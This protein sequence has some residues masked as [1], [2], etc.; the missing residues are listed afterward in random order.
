MGINFLH[1]N[2]FVMSARPT[3]HG[4]RLLIHIALA[5]TA[6]ELYSIA[7][8]ASKV[9]RV[10]L[11][12]SL[13]L[14]ITIKIANRIGDTIYACKT[15]QLEFGAGVLLCDGCTGEE[16]PEHLSNHTFFRVRIWHAPDLGDDA[17]TQAQTQLRNIWYCEECNFVGGPDFPYSHQHLDFSMRVGDLF[18]D[19][20]FPK[21]SASCL[22]N[23][24]KLYQIPEP[25]QPSKVKCMVCNKSIGLYVWNVFC[26][27]C[28]Q[29][30]CKVCIETQRAVHRHTLHWIRLDQ[31]TAQALQVT[32]LSKFLS[33]SCDSCG[34]NFLS[35]S[36]TGL[37]CTVCRNFHFCL[38]N[39]MQK[40]HRLPLEHVYCKG[41]LSSWELKFV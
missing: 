24:L 7:A 25:P 2:L 15:C 6:R 9:I 10:F 32:T 19:A 38:A 23:K 14:L 39:C 37:L 21:I 12:N 34:T 22:K 40:Q 18:I 26:M 30:I 11:C 4:N 27:K 41:R 28:D 17:Q 13:S 35:A 33:C 31:I 1:T 8:G 3:G 29:Q 36:F 5:F 16:N 20:N